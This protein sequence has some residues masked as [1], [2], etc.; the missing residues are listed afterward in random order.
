M[1]Y[2]NTEQGLIQVNLGYLSDKLQCPMDIGL[3]EKDEQGRWRVPVSTPQGLPTDL[4]SEQYKEE[5]RELAQR[6]RD[7]HRLAVEFVVLSG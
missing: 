5:L 6:L 2:E 3:M 1:L 7:E 4:S